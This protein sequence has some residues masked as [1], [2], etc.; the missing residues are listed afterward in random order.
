MTRLLKM[1]GLLSL[2]CCASF[3]GSG[4]AAPASAHQ[5]HSEYFLTIFE[6]VETT[7]AVF[8]TS[9]GF[10]KCPKAKFEA[11]HVGTT[12]EEI[13]GVPQYE[14][15]SLSGFWN[16]ALS[17]NGCRYMLG[18]A[19][20]GEHGQFRLKCEGESKM[21]LVFSA[22][23]I[24]HCTMKFGSQTAEKGVRYVNAGAGSSR[25]F[26]VTFTAFGLSYERSGVSCS[27]GSFKDGG[28]TGSM[29]VRGYEDIKGAKGKQV[30]VWVE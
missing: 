17:M 14:G 19:T 15:C 26:T 6:G 9:V 8:H 24:T 7:P 22:G 21:E 18:G 4:L 1:F 28:I 11:T 13:S 25:D 16:M 23:G 2:V 3:A 12:W 27:S 10:V 30:G 29:T 20:V 5:F